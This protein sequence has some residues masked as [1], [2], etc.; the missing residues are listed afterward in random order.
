MV[1]I[2]FCRCPTISTKLGISPHC[3]PFP[4]PATAIAK[5]VVTDSRKFLLY[6]NYRFRNMPARP[7]V[8]FERPE[9]DC[10]P[11]PSSQSHGVSPRAVPILL[12]AIKPFSWAKRSES[13]FCLARSSVRIGCLVVVRLIWACFLQIHF[14]LAHSFSAVCEL[15][16]WVSFGRLFTNYLVK[17]DEVCNS[18]LFLFCGEWFNEFVEIIQELLVAVNYGDAFIVTASWPVKLCCEVVVIEVL[19]K[20]I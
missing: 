4:H 11:V 17:V 18:E 16:G 20:R 9:R 7:A 2:K 19:I 13:A 14:H 3:P 12:F 8:V 1:E 15:C 6:A 5:S 10:L